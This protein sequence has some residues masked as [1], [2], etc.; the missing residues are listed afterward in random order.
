M[1]DDKILFEIYGGKLTI[2]L[3]ELLETYAYNNANAQIPYETRKDNSHKI[4][5]I[6][7][8]IIA[9]ELNK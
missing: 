9:R 8:I 1:N 3:L 6:K 5:I 4:A 2:E 7:T